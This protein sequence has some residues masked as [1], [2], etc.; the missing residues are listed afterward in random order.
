MLS[1]GWWIVVQHLIS[2][3][4]H[5]LSLVCAWSSSN[6]V[7]QQTSSLL[8]K[9]SPIERRQCHMWASTLEPS[10]QHIYIYVHICISCIQNTCVNWWFRWFV[11]FCTCSWKCVINTTCNKQDY[12]LYIAYR[13]PIDCLSNALDARMLSHHGHGPGPEPKAQKGRGS[14]MLREP[15][16]SARLRGHAVWKPNHWPLQKHKKKW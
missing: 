3:L 15:A 2:Y 9:P 4:H 1:Y 13:M 6:F 8:R 5:V 11:D 16:A 14:A 10:I 12:L 7:G